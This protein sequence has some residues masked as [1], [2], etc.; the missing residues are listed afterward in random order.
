MKLPGKKVAILGLGVS[1]FQS[2]LF[3][4]KQGYH[5]WV[6]DQGDV[7]TIRERAQSLSR[8][9]IE[10]EY[11]RHTEGRILRSDW[12]L[13]SPGIPPESSVYRSLLKKKIP[14][15][16]EIEVAGWHSKA[17]KVVG[18]TGTS[19]KTT[20]STLLTRVLQKKG[21]HAMSCGNIGNPWIGELSK[22]TQETVVV[23]E[24]S[25][26]QLEHCH[27]FRPHM[28]VLLNLSPN[29]EDWHGDMKSY[30]TSK[31]KLFQNQVRG[32]YAVI[33]EADHKRFFPDYPFRAQTVYFD[34]EPQGNPNETV[35]RVVSKFFGCSDKLADE[36]FKNFEG[37]EHRLEKFLEVRDVNYI[38]D[39]KCTTP[40]SLIWALEKFPDGKVVLLAGGHPK[41]RQFE[42]LR[43]LIKRKVKQMILIGEARPLLREAWQGCCPTFET[44]DFKEAI[45]RAHQ[46]AVTRDNVLLSPGCASFDMFQNY[47]ERGML[48]KKLVRETVA[49]DR[50]QTAS[51]IS[52]TK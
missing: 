33:C 1:G 25:S 11:G 36:V 17:Q 24:I 46:A 2:A 52:S 7:S 40:A 38:N 8:E 49:Q 16:S 26:F 34:K 9:G 29:H 37:I 14:I 20:V 22:I 18:I 12:V 21:F 27:Y 35:V 50:S 51:N 4:K 43:D 10:V 31:L 41:S 19:G 44:D 39:S 5:L 6:S 42:S 32:D 3:L 30:V 45:E 15:V 23:L 47:Q 28:G 48:F 13:I